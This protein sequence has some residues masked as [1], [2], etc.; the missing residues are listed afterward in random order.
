MADFYPQYSGSGMTVG[1]LS[2]MASGLNWNE[3]YFNPF[4][5]TAR[6]YYDADLAETILKLKVIEKPGV[7]Y[8][9]LSGNTQLLAMVIQKATNKKLADYLH[10]S[11]W[12]PMGFE[13]PCGLA[14]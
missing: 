8:K 9:Y 12:Q 7:H 2:S 6:A 10:E 14:S 3:S 5:M 1:D 4:G 11:F 13:K